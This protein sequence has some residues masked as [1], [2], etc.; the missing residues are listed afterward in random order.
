MEVLSLLYSG[1]K[2]VRDLIQS[3]EQTVENLAPAL[4]TP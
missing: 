1:N 2:A 4:Q 3:P